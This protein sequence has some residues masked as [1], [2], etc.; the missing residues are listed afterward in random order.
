MPLSARRR[1]ALES[2]P[3]KAKAEYVKGQGQTR[4]HHCHG[5]MPGCKGQC[6]PAM[7]GCVNCW[8]KLPAYLKQKIWAA[9]RPGQEKTLTPS[10]EYLEVAA[11]VQEWVARNYLH[12]EK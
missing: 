12:G 1:K 5:G 6:P 10:W 3:V 2:L 4:E 7:W 8:R 11:E 9:Y